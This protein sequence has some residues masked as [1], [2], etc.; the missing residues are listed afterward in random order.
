MHNNDLI[1]SLL[2]KNKKK[3]VCEVNLSTIRMHS[4]KYK[5]DIKER[6]LTLIYKLTRM[7]KKAITSTVMLR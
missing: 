1:A 6:V 7:P 5:T 4:Y 3:S 2:L